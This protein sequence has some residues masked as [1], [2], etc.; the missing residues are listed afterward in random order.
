MI[1]KGGGQSCRE[2]VFVR[3]IKGTRGTLNLKFV[4][5]KAFY[6][7]CFTPLHGTLSNR[8]RETS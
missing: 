3:D 5:S 8:Q 2:I 4:T 6:Y 7:G 1:E